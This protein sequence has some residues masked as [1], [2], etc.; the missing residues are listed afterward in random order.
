MDRLDI[1]CFFFF[2]SKDAE[3]APWSND[4]DS[5][6]TNPGGE[7]PAVAIYLI[8]I[9]T[10]GEQLF[11]TC[12]PAVGLNMTFIST[13]PPQAGSQPLTQETQRLQHRGLG[14]GTLGLLSCWVDPVTTHSL[15]WKDDQ[16]S[17]T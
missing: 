14:L 10:A 4:N 12:H 6:G 13:K 17:H 15:L 2:F 7:Q 3:L 11:A 9:L 5:L 1:L 16:V 8:Q